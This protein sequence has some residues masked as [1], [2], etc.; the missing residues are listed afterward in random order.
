[1][2]DLAITVDLVVIVVPLAV[3][4]LEATAIGKLKK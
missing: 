3:I 2:I 4:H 1:M